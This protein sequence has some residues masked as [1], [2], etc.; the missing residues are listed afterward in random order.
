MRV[1]RDQWIRESVREILSTIGTTEKKTKGAKSFWTAH[2]RQPRYCYVIVGTKTSSI[3]ALARYHEDKTAV[4]IQRSHCISC[5]VH[6]ELLHTRYPALHET[7]ASTSV[8]G[9]EAK[10]D[11]AL[12]IMKS[13]KSQNH[14]KAFRETLLRIDELGC[15]EN[16]W[17]LR[18]WK[19]LIFLYPRFQTIVKSTHTCWSW[20][21]DK[22]KS[23]SKPDG[24]SSLDKT[25]LYHRLGCCTRKHVFLIYVNANS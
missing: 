1:Q 4:G 24:Q 6:K 16:A 18:Q 13:V 20:T 17:W 9:I 12:P 3:G 19:H 7:S 2:I 11:R 23:D 15:K 21:N 8:G 25:S 5:V 14:R 22:H 10:A